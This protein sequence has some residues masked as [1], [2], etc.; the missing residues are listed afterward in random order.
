MKF[1]NQ[2]HFIQVA[3]QIHNFKYDYSKVNYINTKHKINIICPIHGESLQYPNDHINGCGCPKCARENSAKKH[4]MTTEQ[5]IEKA[6]EIH[7]NKYDYSKVQYERHNIPVTIICPIHGEFEQ[8]PDVHLSGSNCPKCSKVYKPTTE[9]WIE[10]AKIIHDNKYNYSKV[11]YINAY[12]P[13]TIICPEHGEFLQRPS[14]H[15]NGSGCPE[16]GKLNI[17]EKNSISK[18]EFIKKAI[19][20]H[21]NKYDYSKVQ[22]TN[23]RTLI[24]IICPKHGEFNQ[25]PSDHL[26]GSGCPICN[27]SKK[28]ILIEKYLKENNINFIAQYK[29][30][31]DQSINSSGIAKIDFYLPDYNLF[32]EYNGKQHYVPIEYFGGELRFEQQQKRDNYVRNYCKENN[33]KLLEISYDT[34]DQDMLE[35][36]NNQVKGYEF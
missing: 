15:L 22:Y 23:C 9:E 21:G 31:I 11:Q 2:N 1:E 36:I 12:T 32:I 4:K 35:L 30:S 5:F 34:K 25:L 24:T 17:I 16:C 3:N 26:R 19:E 33:I 13:I 7:G 10:K 6:R 20:I 28:E 14:N 27:Y 8:K 18:E 29:I